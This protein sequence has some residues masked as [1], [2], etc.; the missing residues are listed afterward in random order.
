VPVALVF[1]PSLRRNEASDSLQGSMGPGTLARQVTF[2]GDDRLEWYLRAGLQ[3]IESVTGQVSPPADR[4]LGL[5]QDSSERSLHA[6][7]LPAPKD[8]ADEAQLMPLR[9]ESSKATPPRPVVLAVAAVPTPAGYDRDD[10]DA[11]EWRIYALKRRRLGAEREARVLKA[12][13]VIEALPGDTVTS[14]DLMRA[15]V[16]RNTIKQELQNWPGALR[17]KTNERSR[18]TKASA[19]EYL[20]ERWAPLAGPRKRSEKKS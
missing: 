16:P 12:L 19:L 17:S 6:A 5:A 20:V 4:P 10:Q 8:C 13:E 11:R 2:D 14:A 15:E 9:D 3:A 1:W 7:R 18:Y